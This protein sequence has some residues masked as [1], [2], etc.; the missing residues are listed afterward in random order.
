M[1]IA[2]WA[3]AGG[4]RPV[5]VTRF[6][7]VLLVLSLLIGAAACGSSGSDEPTVRESYCNSAKLDFERVIR[8]STDT[9]AE[10]GE[11]RSAR[12]I[13]AL[14]A[15]NGDDWLKGSPRGLRTDSTVILEAARAAARGDFVF[16]DALTTAFL[17]VSEYAAR[18]QSG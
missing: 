8:M 9:N 15:R 7:R 17:K 14:F 4:S 11:R 3:R 13:L 18:C 12:S 6:C 1:A 5:T 16:E 10:P 2:V